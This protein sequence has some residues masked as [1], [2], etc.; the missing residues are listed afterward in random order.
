M[1]LVLALWGGAYISILPVFV[2]VLVDLIYYP[3]TGLPWGTIYG[4]CAVLGIQLVRYLIRTRI[5]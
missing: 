5:M 2:G 3:G 4:L 1:T